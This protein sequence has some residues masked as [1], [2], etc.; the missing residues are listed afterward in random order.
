MTLSDS[1]TPGQMEHGSDSNKGVLP[2]ATALQEPHHQNAQCYI[3]DTLW[4]G[5]I[6][7]QR[8]TQ[9][10]LLPQSTGPAWIR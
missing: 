4:R 1:T 2:K 5:F 6:P 3:L 10:I 8:C 9:C 7:L